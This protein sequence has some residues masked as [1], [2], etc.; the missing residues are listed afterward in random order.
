MPMSQIRVHG[1]YGSGS[2]TRFVRGTDT[3]RPEFTQ[4]APLAIVI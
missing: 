2:P 4:P 1:P 3:A